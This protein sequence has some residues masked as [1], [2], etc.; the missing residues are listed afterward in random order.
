MDEDEQAPI[1]PLVPP[2]PIEGEPLPIVPIDR[3]DPIGDIAQRL[4]VSLKTAE[5]YCSRALKAAHGT[6]EDR[7]DRER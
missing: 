6:A 3:Y 4:G 2:S 7:P 1:I 5:G